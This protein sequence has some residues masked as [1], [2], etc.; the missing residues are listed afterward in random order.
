M[1]P[2]SVINSTLFWSELVPALNDFAQKAMHEI[3]A[4]RTDIQAAANAAMDWEGYTWQKD[5]IH[6]MENVDADPDITGEIELA[7]Q[8]VIAIWK[9]RQT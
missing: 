7:A 1:D 4:Y 9:K 2:M 6:F 8:N 5:L 3:T